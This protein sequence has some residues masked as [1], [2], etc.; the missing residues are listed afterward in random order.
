MDISIDLIREMVACL[1]ASTLDVLRV[2]TDSFKITLERGVCERGVCERGVPV[3]CGGQP[4]GSGTP[5]SGTP[6]PASLSA[7]V[8]A[9]PAAA[10]EP[11]EGTVVKSP[12]VGTFYA[13]SSPDKPAFAVPGKAVKKG[14]TLFIVES[15]KLMNE[16]ASECDGT[17]AELY[18][19]DGQPVEYGQKILRLV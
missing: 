18:V 19:K 1:N 13:S 2:E 8:P 17:V 15:M 4:A 9:K 10:P 3:P 7:P 14:D 11:C 12:I 6:V 16:V 5:A